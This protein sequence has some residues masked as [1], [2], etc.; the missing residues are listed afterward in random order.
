MAGDILRDGGMRGRGPR[1]P[2][3][4]RGAD[5]VGLRGSRQTR[6]PREPRRTSSGDAFEML[7]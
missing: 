7:A 6:R 4:V 3:P 5:G 1:D 2:G